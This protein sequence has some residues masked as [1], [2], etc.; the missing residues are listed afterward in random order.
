[1]EIDKMHPSIM[2]EGDRLKCTTVSPSV[3]ACPVCPKFTT[4]SESVVQRHLLNHVANAV[5][6]KEK[7]ICR[8]NLPCRDGGHFHCP[9]CGTTI[10]RK[11][12]I[13]PLLIQCKNKCDM[14]QLTLA[15]PSQ[16]PS[17]ET[18]L[19]VL[20]SLSVPYTLPPSV[21]VVCVKI[22][23]SYTQ[24]ASPKNPDLSQSTPAPTSEDPTAPKEEVTQDVPPTHVRCPH[25]PLVL[26]KRNLF[27]HI[28]MSE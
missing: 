2:E 4:K 15:P 18:H 12:T 3:F 14:A 7:I 25:C 26:Y 1:M 6:F 20:S 17:P 24:T 21:S 16:P 11:D 13:M 22:D 19:T 28:Q 8:C 27:L 10:I 23:H 5:H 9:F